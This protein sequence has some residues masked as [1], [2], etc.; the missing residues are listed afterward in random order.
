M[1]CAF[2]SGPCEATGEENKNGK[3][4]AASGRPTTSG[5]RRTG[6]PTW[7]GSLRER[8]RPAEEDRPRPLHDPSRLSNDSCFAD[9]AIAPRFLFRRRKR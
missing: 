6:P 9:A 4:K 5:R 1:R 7:L 8:P 3:K 2:T